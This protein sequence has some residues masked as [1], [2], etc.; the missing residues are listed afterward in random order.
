MATLSK[1]YKDELNAIKSKIQESEELERFLDT[2]EEEDYKE[3]QQAFEPLLESLHSTVADKS[4]LQLISFE[5]ALLDDD[6]EGLFLP[7]ILGYS[8]LRGEINE[9]FKYIYPQEHFSEILLF[10]SNSANFE[11]I[12]ARIGQT[13]Q[14][15]FALSTDIWVAD[16]LNKIENKNVRKYLQGQQLLKFHDPEVIKSK[17]LK[18]KRQFEKFNYLVPYFP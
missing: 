14:I 15:G 10:I 9:R 18:Y 17:Y 16:L 11:Y 7:R 13:V 12:W 4:P 6:F 2:E 8:V 1:N 5:K 3:M